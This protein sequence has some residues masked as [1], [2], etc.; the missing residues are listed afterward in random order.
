[1][2]VKGMTGSNHCFSSNSDNNRRGEN[3]RTDIANASIVDM[4]GKSRRKGKAGAQAMR[5]G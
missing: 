4:P 2:T 3:R 1:M 5:A